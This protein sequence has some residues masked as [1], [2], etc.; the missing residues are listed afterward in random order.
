MNV[1]LLNW[2]IFTE[3]QLSTKYR[4]E[5]WVIV[6]LALRKI[7]GTKYN[8][9]KRIISGI[10]IYPKWSEA[11]DSLIAVLKEVLFSVPKETVKETCERWGLWPTLKLPPPFTLLTSDFLNVFLYWNDICDRT[12]SDDTFLGPGLKTELW[13]LEEKHNFFTRG[14][15]SF[16]LQNCSFTSSKK[17]QEG[18]PTSAFFLSLSTGRLVAP[19]HAGLSRDSGLRFISLR[20][21]VWSRWSPLLHFTCGLKRAWGKDVQLGVLNSLAGV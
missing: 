4:G 7:T 8:S 11:C 12:L 10:F 19:S 21:W 5:Y 13:S 15:Y 16:V 14:I 9:K 6:P 1:S 2:Q 20:A 17:R 18:S 3:N